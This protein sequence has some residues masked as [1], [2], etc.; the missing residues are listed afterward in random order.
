MTI[1]PFSKDDN[2]KA[3]VT[4]DVIQDYFF[5]I[6]LYPGD[7]EIL[8]REEYPIQHFSAAQQCS[9]PLPIIDDFHPNI[10]VVHLPL[11]TQSIY[12]PG[13]YSDF[14]EILFMSHFLSKSKDK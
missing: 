6:P 7:R 5:F 1:S 9:R 3:S 2:P 14:Q 4:Q 11:N 12:G 10:K 8:L 13:S